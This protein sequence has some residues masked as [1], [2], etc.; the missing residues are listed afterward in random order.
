MSCFVSYV[1]DTADKVAECS[2]RCPEPCK[3]TKYD[4]RLSYAS[5]VSNSFSR[6]I[7]SQLQGLNSSYSFKVF[8]NK[9]EKERQEFIR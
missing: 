3:Y 7:S 2:N 6:A 9:T 4:T 8:Q 5:A 1:G